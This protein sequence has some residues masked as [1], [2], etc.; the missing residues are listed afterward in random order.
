MDDFTETLNFDTEASS[1]FKALNLSPTGLDCGGRF[2]PLDAIWR[3]PRTGGTVY[4]GNQ[5]A[6]ESKEMME[7]A[8]ITRVV[9]LCVLCFQ[10]RIYIQSYIYDSIYIYI[11]TR[12]SCML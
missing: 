6:A 5:S 8:G 11:D 9:S 4:V 10:E 2:N 1:L 3:H 12:R 7:R